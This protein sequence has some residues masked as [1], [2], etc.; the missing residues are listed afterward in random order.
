MD[1]TIAQVWQLIHE[2]SEQVAVNQK[3][4]SA[5]QAQA[6]SLKSKSVEADTGFS[7]RR[8]STDISKEVFDSELERQN[9]YAIIENQALSQENKQLSQLL[10]EYEVTLETIMEKFRHHDLAARRHELNLQSYY[11][12]LLQSTETQT[13][14]DGMS[15]QEITRCL[16][17]LA[18]HLRGLLRSLAGEEADAADPLFDSYID[19]DYEPESIVDAK[20]LR[21]L[22]ETLDDRCQGG[23]SGEEERAD[24]AIER[25]REISRLAQ[26]NAEMRR[27]LEIDQESLDAVG[28]KLDPDRGEARLAYSLPRRVPSG[29]EGQG[30]RTLQREAQQQ[31]FQAGASGVEQ[32]QQQQQTSDLQPGMRFQGG[33]RPGIFGGGRGRGL[34][35]GIGQSPGAP[36]P[37]WNNQP[38]SPAPVPWQG[39]CGPTLDLSR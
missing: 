17:R 14:C 37:L 29:T 12:K 32:Q 16:R 33:R 31:Y 24:W 38:S 8:I 26:E 25:E 15:S 27:I 23:Y 22:L 39:V 36:S 34:S 4:A 35:I 1:S 19:P 2:L 11:E 13:L 10:K 5:I 18:H 7:L 9:A 3:A 21:H 28:V 30:P 6:N 20:E